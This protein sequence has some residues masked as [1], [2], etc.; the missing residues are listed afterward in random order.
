MKQDHFYAFFR[1]VM[2]ITRGRKK[3]D[4]AAATIFLR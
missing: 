3:R 1:F 4:N 2:T